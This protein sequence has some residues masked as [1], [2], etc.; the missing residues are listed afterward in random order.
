MPSAPM[1]S[2]ACRFLCAANRSDGLERLT[3]IV[4]DPDGRR[5]APLDIDTCGC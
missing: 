2:T 1:A 3:A 4:D 5:I